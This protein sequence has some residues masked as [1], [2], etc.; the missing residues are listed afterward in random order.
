MPLKSLSDS[1]QSKC[2][3]FHIPN[4]EGFWWQFS[5]ALQEILCLLTQFHTEARGS[6][7]DCNVECGLAHSEGKVPQ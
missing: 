3:L 7:F 2:S 1:A 6:Q 5:S 4:I